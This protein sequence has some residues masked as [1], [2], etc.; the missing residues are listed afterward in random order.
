MGFTTIATTADGSRYIVKY[1]DGVSCVVWGEMSGYRGLKT[2]H[3]GTMSLR[4]ADVTLAT[5]EMTPIIVEE[6]LQQYLRSE[7]KKGKY[8]AWRGRRYS[9]YNSEAEFLKYMAMRAATRNIQGR[10]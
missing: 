8:I 5:I 2:K 7:Q 6:L 10:Y 1:H 3:Q 9:I 4:V